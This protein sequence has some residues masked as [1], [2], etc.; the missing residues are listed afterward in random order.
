MLIQTQEL[1]DG[2]SPARRA[3]SLAD[4]ATILG[5]HRAT[6]HRL[7]Q[8]GKLRAISGFGRLKISDVEINRFLTSTAD[9]KPRVDREGVCR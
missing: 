3:Y 4:A 7:I 2:A 5:V 8:A 6:V 1:S 9:Y